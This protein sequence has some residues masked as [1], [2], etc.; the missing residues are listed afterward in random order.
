[1]PEPDT[2]TLTIV[3]PEMTLFEGQVTKII[4][5]GIYQEIALLPDHTPLYAQLIKGDIHIYQSGKKVQTLPV[6]GGVVRIKRN[7]ASIIVGFGQEKIP[8]PH[9][10]ASP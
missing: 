1:M 4:A 7:L 2:F 8:L 9:F 5:P 10:S 3:T 6:D